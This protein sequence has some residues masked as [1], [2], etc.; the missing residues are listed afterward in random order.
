MRYAKM[1]FISLKV[2]TRLFQIAVLQ[3]RHLVW[4]ICKIQYISTQYIKLRL[5]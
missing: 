1:Y 3:S 5:I 4:F 2:I